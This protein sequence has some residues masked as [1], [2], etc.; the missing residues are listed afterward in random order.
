MR[1]RT[2]SSALIPALTLAL[3]SIAAQGDE[4]RDTRCDDSRRAIER[5][6]ASWRGDPARLGTSTASLPVPAAIDA[7][8]VDPTWVAEERLRVE[9]DTL[10]PDRLRELYAALEWDRERI[11]HCLL[12]PLVAA[13]RTRIPGDPVTMFGGS[14]RMTQQALEGVGLPDSWRPLSTVD[15]PEARRDHIAVWTGSHMLVWGGRADVGALGSGGR[16]DPVLD[17][18]TPISLVNAPPPRWGHVGLWTGDRLFVWG[19]TSGGSIWDEGA[20]L[21]DGALYDPL[22][23]QWQPVTAMDAPTARAF[24]SNTWTGNRVFVWGGHG[25]TINPPG[26]FVLCGSLANDGALYD[27]VLNAWEPIAASP[28]GP[29]A[30][31]GAVWTGSRVFVN[32]GY[33][34]DPFVPLGFACLDGFS[35]NFLSLL[36]DPTT[37]AWTPAAND[38]LGL[39]FHTIVWTGTV[40]IP[41]GGF[42]GIPTPRSYDPAEDDWPVLSSAGKPPVGEAIWTGLALISWGAERIPITSGGSDSD[43]GAAYVPDC[44]SWFPTTTVGAPQERK[45]H[46]AVW[47]GQQMLVWGGTDAGG[48]LNSGGA[49]T[50]GVDDGDGDGAICDNCPDVGNPGQEDQDADGQGDACDNCPLDPA[51]DADADGVCG[52]ADNCAGVP[53]GDQSDPDLDGLGSACDD[54]P[55]AD[56]P[57]QAD[58]DGDGVGDV[59][60]CEPLDPGDATPQAV[61]L[62]DILRSDPTT[63]ALAWQP[64][65]GADA[66]SIS[67]GFLSTLAAGSFGDC[68]IDGVESTTFEDADLPP[69]GD[70]HFYIVQGQSFDCGLGL[71]GFAGDGQARVNLSP[72]ACSGTPVVDV[73]AA[74]DASV[75]GTVSGTFADTEFSDDV[76]QSIT[77]EVTSGPPSSRV[78]VLEHHWTFQVPAGSR[79]ELHVEGFRT[80]SPDGDEFEF[81]YSIGGAWLPL[82]VAPLPTAD[83]DI[84]LVIP[85]GSSVAGT[86]TIRVDDTGRTAPATDVDTVSFDRLFI[87]SVP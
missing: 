69:S 63:I 58:G 74:S 44:D 84:D 25:E 83:D 22:T 71:L 6:Y 82:G 31:A 77:E 14:L 80:T 23:D 19:G 2:L 78:S 37:D 45:N 24:P 48:P 73:P 39:I 86:V 60:D 16:Y 61:T 9:R 27:P 72:S 50:P 17:S 4:G 57:L 18:W 47:T 62:A 70:G 65:A 85:L 87:R 59:C 7:I 21:G 41:W 53:N 67:R 79:I 46:T 35:G 10:I 36:Y 64:A 42:T 32:G 3:A 81:F 13:R 51:N 76:V 55:V 28:Q 66:Y 75:L 43:E 26:G 15:A 52:D 54:C 34:Q 49:Y 33:F 12:R 56:D 20:R 29:R 38:P 8:E 5:V 68:R 1:W 30:A 40:A 11:D